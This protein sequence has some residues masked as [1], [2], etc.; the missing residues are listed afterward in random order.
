MRKNE[1]KELAQ[2]IVRTYH[3]YIAKA[4]QFQIDRVD[5]YI[6]AG[7]INTKEQLDDLYLEVVE[8]DIKS[9]YNDRFVGYYD[10]W[11]RYN[12]ADEGRAYDAGVKRAT[13]EPKCK[14]EMR[15]IPCN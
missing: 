9:G 13:Q 1:I 3:P 11:Y 8:K 2:E 14:D 15:I 7:M 6:Y 10:K 4:T 12:R 5:R